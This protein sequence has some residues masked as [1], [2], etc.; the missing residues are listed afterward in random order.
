MASLN[1]VSI[2]GNLGKDPDVRYMPDGNPVANLN[3]ATTIR[4]KDKAS[5]EMKEETEWHRISLRNR[6]AEVASEYL[7]KGS[8]VYVEGRLRTR[9]WTDK[10]NIE[11]Y[12]T[13]IIG[14]HLVLLGSRQDGEASSPR[15]SAQPQSKPAQ[16]RQAAPSGSGFDDFEDDIPF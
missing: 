8:Q 10:E 4:W 15:P 12:T 5:G 13:E 16:P 9:K 2:I 14:S 7:K 11:R 3:V 6:Q 1:K